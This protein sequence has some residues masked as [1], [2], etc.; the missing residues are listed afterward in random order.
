VQKSFETKPLSQK[1]PN[2]RWFYFN[3]R[4]DS[5]PPLTTFTNNFLFHWQTYLT[6]HI[7]VLHKIGSA[8]FEW[9]IFGNFHLLV[10]LGK[11]SYS[12]SQNSAV[13]PIVWNNICQVE[14]PEILNKLLEKHYCWCH[15]LISKA[16]LRGSIQLTHMLKIW[17]HMMAMCNAWSQGD[18]MVALSQEISSKIFCIVIEIDELFILIFHIP[19][20]VSG[21]MCVAYWCKI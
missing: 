8:L 11:Q 12:W 18:S 4:S 20:R 17:E 15:H 21:Q 16:I 10:R 1:L 3:N 19:T 13:G 7:Q 6:L 2:S 14:R 5:L 9:I